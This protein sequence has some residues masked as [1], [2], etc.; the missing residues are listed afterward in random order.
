MQVHHRTGARLLSEA[1]F[2]IHSAA[3]ECTN[4]EFMIVLCNGN[5]SGGRSTTGV[6]G[7]G[8]GAGAG[9]WRKRVYRPTL[10]RG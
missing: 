10:T 2:D 5:G 4:V 8:G 7:A 9:E 3:P 6:D 1:R